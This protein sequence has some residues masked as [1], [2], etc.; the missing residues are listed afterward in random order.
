[1]KKIDAVFSFLIAEIKKIS[2][3]TDE[4]YWEGLD[5]Y[6]RDGFDAICDELTVLKSELEE[7]RQS[8]VSKVDFSKIRIVFEKFNELFSGYPG[9]NY[10]KVIYQI[11]MSSKIC[12]VVGAIPDED[13]N[14]DFGFFSC[15]LNFTSAAF[16]SNVSPLAGNL[17]WFNPSERASLDALIFCDT[18]VELWYCLASFSEN[19]DFLLNT[20]ILVCPSACLVSQENVLSLLKIYML[21][22]GKKVT[23]TIEYLKSPKNSSINSFDPLLNYAQFGEVVQIMGEYVER[24]DVLSK[25]LS[26]YHVIENFMF[27]YPIV[28]LERSRSGVMFS[29]RDFKS[30]YKAV[31]TKEQEAV[32][33][34]MKVAFALPFNAINIGQEI[35]QLWAAFITAQTPNLGD[36]DDFLSRLDVKRSSVN[37]L[38]T[39][40]TFFSTA[41]YRIRC[42]V[43]H[44]KETEYHISSENY[45]A[46]C[47]LVLEEF[48]LPALEELI[49]LLLSKENDVVWY[50]S[51]SIKLWS[52]TA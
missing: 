47:R 40:V 4:A 11:A 41:L 1:M 49:F 19:I 18:D 29:I 14:P 23:K 7:S 35:Y 28:K 21:A 44:N 36:I 34:L 33:S 31:E 30:L 9:F 51:D 15:S 50:K 20:E 26:I 38:P 8:F 5:P 43:V 16:V 6:L 32:I 12:E 52:K 27:K 22:S 10:Q 48:Y 37:S 45:S 17:V 2:D 46:G 3:D 24:K 42:S 25:Y 39:F 13:I